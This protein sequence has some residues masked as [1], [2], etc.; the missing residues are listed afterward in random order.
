MIKAW[1]KIVGFQILSFIPGGSRIYRW[2]QKHLTK[3]I[4]PTPERIGSKMDVGLQYWKWLES[5]GYATTLRGGTY[6]DFGAGWHPSIPL[7]FYSLGLQHLHLL[8]VQ[9]AIDRECLADTIEIFREISDKRK[10]PFSRLPGLAQPEE[11]MAEICQRLG[12]Q[13]AAPYDDLLQRMSGSVDLVTSTQVL[14]HIDRQTLRECFRA[15][16]GALKPGGVFLATI[17]LRDLFGGLTGS[18]SPYFSLQFSPTVWEKCINSRAMAYNRLKARD[19]RDLL[20]EAGFRLAHFE[21]DPVPEID[22]ATLSKTRVHPCFKDYSPA[23]LAA[24]HL[25]FAAERPH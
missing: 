18:I 13:Y 4:R 23:E 8:D 9:R 10:L 15:I 7:V 17:H 24:R 16:F 19:Y 14:L 12:I 22:L 20:E 1:T 3:S 2:A 11:G 25:F 5:H 6:V 21:V